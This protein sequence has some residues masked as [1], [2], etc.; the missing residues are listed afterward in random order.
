MYDITFYR[1]GRYYRPN[2]KGCFT[3]TFNTL[4][5]IVEFY[6]KSKNKLYAPYL[7][8]ELSR[9]EARIIAN[10]LSSQLMLK[11]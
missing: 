6:L 4:S 1:I 5:E 7:L 10:K 3:K 11:Q 2:T 9:N 8:K